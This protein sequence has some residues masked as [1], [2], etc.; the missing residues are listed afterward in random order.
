MI[1]ELDLVVLTRDL[2]NERLAAGDVGTVVLMHQQGAGYEVEFT[3]LSGDTSCHR[4]PRCVR[5][6]PGRGARDRSCHATRS[7]LSRSRWRSDAG[8]QGEG[9]QSVTAPPDPAP[10]ISSTVIRATSGQR[11]GRARSRSP[12]RGGRRRCSRP[13]TA[14]ACR[15]A[16]SIASRNLTDK[17]ARYAVEIRVFDKGKPAAE[18]RSRENRSDQPTWGRAS[19]C[20]SNPRPDSHAGHL[21]L[22]RANFHCSIAAGR[23]APTSNIDARLRRRQARSSV[24][25]AVHLDLIDFR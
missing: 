21:R 23:P 10:G 19:M 22:P 7:Q 4:H 15:A 3:T 13:A 14:T 20:Q 9:M 24:A 11:C 12:S 16:P 25:N 2:P 8:A 5:R 18:K 1:G 17:P 6:A